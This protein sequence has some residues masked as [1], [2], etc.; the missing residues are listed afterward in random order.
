MCVGFSWC[1]TVLQTWRALSRQ[2]YE[3]QTGDHA[4][5]SIT[6]TVR[7]INTL[8]RRPIHF[9]KYKKNNILSTLLKAADVKQQRSLKDDITHHHIA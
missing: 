5:D 2:F 4:S 6:G 9:N 3:H 8:K 7:Y 1:A